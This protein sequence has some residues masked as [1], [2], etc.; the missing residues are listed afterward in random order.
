MLNHISHRGPLANFANWISFPLCE[1]VA[2]CDLWSLGEICHSSC[3]E[4]DKSLSNVTFNSLLLNSDNIESDGLGDWSAL[5]DS[6]DITDS[7]S[8]ESW[9]EMCWQVVMSLFKSVV[10]L[11][12]MQVISSKN[13][14]SSHLCGK[15]DTLKDSASDGNIWGEWA[16]MVNVLA[17]HCCLWGLET[18]T[19]FLVVSWTWSTF[20]S[21]YFFRVIENSMLLL[22]SS[23]SL[24]N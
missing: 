21:K 12:V 15:D 23:F 22:E 13:H 9:G 24:Y 18:K 2:Q 8:A 7:G 4:H 14:S 5:T 10:F 6:D 19:D 1:G 16:L 20:L 3:S 17:F 11:D